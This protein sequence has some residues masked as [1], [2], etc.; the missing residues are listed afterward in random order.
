MYN[1]STI[2]D[3]YINSLNVDYYLRH[4][5]NTFIVTDEYY[6]YV[7]MSCIIHML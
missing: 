2:I 7:V 5:V 6:H 1:N 3:S 4:Q